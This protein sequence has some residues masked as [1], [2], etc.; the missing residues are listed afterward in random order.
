MDEEIA[1]G[2]ALAGSGALGALV[3]CGVGAGPRALGEAVLGWLGPAQWVPGVHAAPPGLADDAEYPA[4]QAFA[5][6]LVAERAGDLAGS[7]DPDAL[8]RAARLLRTRTPLGPF[9]V[10]ER[11]RQ[12][13]HAPAIVTWE[14]GPGG[15]VRR[16]VW[17]PEG[18][19]GAPDRLR[20]SRP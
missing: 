2:E 9:A 3:V 15:P 19:G 17:S 14:R 8:W 18:P 4:A 10:D 20:D 12:V 11:G 1:A 5:A 13:A 6:C 16:L 7:L